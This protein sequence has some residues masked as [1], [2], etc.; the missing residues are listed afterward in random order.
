VEQLAGGFQIWPRRISVRIDRKFTFSV[1]QASGNVSWTSSNSDVASVNSNGEIS[2]LKVGQ[3]T[4]TARDALNRTAS[5]GIVQIVSTSS[6]GGGCV[7]TSKTPDGP[8]E[9][10]NQAL[11]LGLPILAAGFIRIISG[12]RK[13]QTNA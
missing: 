7:P 13:R 12:R 4:I 2:A 11:N 3:V 6:G 8:W 5:T 10:T 9:T 1:Y